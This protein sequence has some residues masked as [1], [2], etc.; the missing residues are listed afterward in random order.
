M[1]LLGKSAARLLTFSLTLLLCA[2]G[3]GGGG[4][5]KTT[6][7]PPPPPPVKIS[8]TGAPLASVNEMAIYKFQVMVKNASST[9]LSFSIANLPTW[10]TFDK[11]TGELAG[12]PSFE[13]AGLYENIV[14]SVKDGA[15]SASLSAFNVQVINV[16]RLPIVT[17][18]ESVEALEGK[19][20]AITVETTDLD[21]DSLSLSLEGQPDW[22]SFDE[23]SS[24]IIG[25]ASL[26]DAGNYQFQ[27]IADDGHS[28]QASKQV[29]VL[30]K[31]A[32]EVRGKVIDGYIQGAKVY[33]DE[34]SNDALDDDEF[35]AITDEKGDYVLILPL[36]KISVL[37]KSSVRAYIGEGAIDVSRPELDFSATPITLSLPPID[38]EQITD[39]VY[40]GAVI[41]PFSQQLY[42]MV[43][44][45]L[46]MLDSGD[47]SVSELQYFIDRAKTI[48][49]R[50][51]IDEGNITL[52]S[53][54]TESDVY[55]II[56]G[57]FIAHS[58]SLS[59]IAQQ[60]Q[61]FVDRYIS[62][63]GAADFDGDG[64]PNDTDTD[65]DGDNVSDSED[66]FPFDPT[67]W[68]DSDGDGVGDNAD[69]YPNNANCSVESDGNGDTCY[70]DLLASNT[71]TLSAISSS[72]VAYFYQQDGLLIAYDLITQ[73]VLN[74]QQVENV[75]SMIFHEGH[76]RLYLGLSTEELKYAADDYSLVDFLPQAQCVNALVDA[77]DFLIVLDC[78]GYAGTYSTFNRD[79]RLLDNSENH[80]DSSRTNTWDNVN[81]RLFHFNDGIS[82]NDLY[83]RTVNDAGEFVDVVESPHHGDYSIAGPIVVS[84]DG[85][86]VLL[87]TGDIYD[88]S[89]LKW[90]K[91]LGERFQQ[92]FW[93]K[94]NDLVVLLQRDEKIH[95]K[96][97][98]GNLNLVEIDE[99]TG[100]LKVVKSFTDR[101]IIITEFDE[102]LQVHD[103]LPSN[104]SDNDGVIN[105]EDAFP[106]DNTAS[107]DSDFDGYPN[108]WNDGQSGAGSQLQI[109][110]FPQDSACWLTSHGSAGS[111]NFL[112]TQPNFT[113]DKT[114]YDA[115]GNIYFLSVEN[116]RVYRWSA[117]TREFTNPL[118]LSVGIFRDYGRSRVMAY[119][120]NHNRLYLG[121][122]SGIISYFE[123]GKQNES[124]LTA[125]GSAVNGIAA[126][127]NY[128]LA[129]NDD[130]AW[131]THYILDD[132]GEITDSKDWN[133]HSS[134]YAW[135]SQNSRVYFLRDG[136]SPND[137]HY[138][139]IDQTLG[140]I[141]ADGESPYHSSQNISHPVRVSDDGRYIILGSGAVFN[142]ADLTLKS[143][144]ELRLADVYSLGDKLYSVE[145]K[146]DLSQVKIWKFE[147]LSLTGL[148]EFSGRALAITRHGDDLNLVSILDDGSLS[149]RAIGIVDSDGDGLPLW[150]ENKYG[151]D[152]NDASD[153]VLDSDNDG[154]SNLQEYTLKTNPIIADTDGDGLL[155]GA[156]V[157]THS[158]SPLE[159]DSDK[160]GLSDGAEV[161]EHGTNPLSAD[162]DNDGLTDSQEILEYN[163]NPLNSDTD[164]DGL[165]D[166]Y[167]VNNRLDINNNDAN[168]DTDNDGLVNID[169]QTHRT[170]PNNPDSDNDKLNDGDEVHTHRT[171]PLN[172]DTDNDKMP[173]GWEVR[174]AFAPLSASD[175]NTDFDADGFSNKLEFFLV[176]DPTDI[177]NVPIIEP[178]SNHQ[179]NAG[180]N[181]FIPV[182]INPANLSTRWTVTLGD[183]NDMSPAIVDNGKVILTG[184]DYS[185]N[186]TLFN[187]NARN[188]SLNWSNTYDNLYSISAPSYFDNKAYIQLKSQ[189]S[190]K[191]TAIDM[192]SGDE[193]FASNLRLFADLDFS[194]TIL[195]DAVYLAGYK[196]NAENG[197]ELWNLNRQYCSSRSEVIDSE[198]YYY[199]F[200]GFKIASNETGEIIAS[201][202]EGFERENC[203]S[204]VYSKTGNVYANINSSIFAF[205]RQTAEVVWKIPRTDNQNF[206]GTPAVALG[207]VYIVKSNSLFVFDEYTGN[208]LWS[209]TPENNDNL[210]TNI[211]VSTNLVFVQ[212]YTNT[213]AIDLETQQQVW[214]YPASGKFTLSKEGALFITQNNGVVTAINLSGD[215]DGDG[216]DDWWEDLYGFDSE[217]EEDA[218]LDT[219]GDGL[220]NLEEF[221]N[222]TDPQNEDSDRDGLSDFAEVITYRSNPLNNDTDNDGMP[223]HWEVIHGFNL[224][225]KFDADADADGDGISNLNEFKENT[226]PTDDSSKPSVIDTLHISFETDVI[227]D[228]WVIDESQSS[229][230]GISRLESSNG[231]H[232]IFSSGEAAITYTNFFNGN[233]LIF[234]FKAQCQYNSSLSIYIDD[235]LIAHSALSTEWRSQE[236]IVPRGRHSIMFKTNDCGV[237]LDNLQFSPLLSLFNMNIETVTVIGQDLRFFNFNKQFTHSIKI[238][239]RANNDARDLT[240]LEDGRIAIFNGV[241]EPSLS[242]YNPLHGTWRHR[243]YDDWGIVNNSTYGGIA[244]FG[245]NVFVTDM[246]IAGDN[247][248]G[249]IRFDIASNEAEFF[250]GE[251]YIDLTV[252]L[253]GLIYALTGRQV[254]KYDPVTMA[255]LTSTTIT[256]ARA[257]AV[258]ADSNLFTASWRGVVKRYDANGVE[259]EQVELS[260]F[261]DNA[262][263]SFYDINISKNNE[264]LLTN[265]GFEVFVLE[266]DFSQFIR[267]DDNIRGAFIALVPFVDGDSDGM[268]KW[269]EER[270][271]FSDADGTDAASDLD[272]EGLTNLAEYLNKTDPS[273]QDT[274]NDLLDDFV[275]VNDHE[276]NPLV[277]DTDKDNLSDG[278]EVLTHLTDPLLIDTDGDTFHDGDEVLVYETDPNDRESKPESV[279]DLNI[280]FS[281]AEL[282]DSWSEAEDSDAAW[283][284]ENEMIRSG[285]ISDNQQS[286]IEYK[287]VFSA[288]ALSFDSLLDSEGCCDYLEIHVDGV[289]E[290]QISTQE[291]QSNQLILSAGAHSITFIYRKD[292]SVSN[293]QDAV[294]IDNL[295]F[296]TN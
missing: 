13:D 14:I 145:N 221:Q 97:Y 77:A 270:F 114:V 282:S 265:I 278:D 127:G 172:R 161:N 209:W 273:L 38:V 258:D 113:P 4:S 269:W 102:Q 150:W 136:T 9:S 40:Q 219:D 18:Q 39:D 234:D 100:T 128:V 66:A 6:E 203:A 92:A 86:S 267:Q 93:L 167:E 78:N 176:S 182:T 56:F 156:E 246:S 131:N 67:E 290:L 170:D 110:A 133:R 95:L 62:Q 222:S 141:T 33:L 242:I 186:H 272:G 29:T 34:N 275:E 292:G 130:G 268:P 212:D 256:E 243:E 50:K 73:K 289:K 155:D 166:L 89:T 80:Y 129:E 123:L 144:L 276:T 107:L 70:V 132:E 279:T 124:R 227:P 137:L 216:I 75:T 106:L 30:I 257:I 22:I 188:G 87:G 225:N 231:D 54:Q 202:D 210:R 226:N 253:D 271:G 198:Y 82:P 164:G 35:S 115:D 37:S 238:P 122:N 274:D 108:S 55:R 207:Q 277:T 96:R 15:D 178:W 184:K 177:N 261:Y 220:N 76:Q 1:L 47:I 204:L 109:D 193:V 179:A 60:A 185:N 99:F 105:I 255:L 28:E 191:L 187:L 147:D 90:K 266:S 211:L 85:N 248:A 42:V 81:N 190:T 286:K 189:A 91:S 236:I 296:T 291:W 25:K 143:N 247:T 283:I 230:W 228:G 135:N 288:G 168:V 49:T 262:S 45:K 181:G 134:T 213:Y 111:C 229:S 205:N 52:S 120:M 48:I 224:L 158:T 98:D 71:S 169:E 194:P 57:D 152:D 197:E 68:R 59:T 74:T 250:S 24:S 118:I 245:D 61:T 17:L 154:L 121:Y 72:S 232:S 240:I 263:G 83:Y 104:D 112:S 206:N 149:V 287:N 233:K 162:S 94:N 119:S 31:E 43:A 218:L 281:A 84:N 153:A 254:D 8:L 295:T 20:L 32:V 23:E 159:A 151:F 199:F 139:T 44:D 88:V 138:E 200:D 125:L 239:K 148:L 294:F 46:A 26:S 215:S 7:P 171:L 175:G 21:A 142:A 146:D 284:L 214:S 79:G 10:A 183:I 241:F 201:N 5:S 103:Y 140:H 27:F 196:F 116:K 223:D 260:D 117:A 58:T 244:H 16:N 11:T 249:I 36:D 101:A 19:Q 252:G 293:G 53:S 192:V 51:I 69:A 251:E 264:L 174:F 2:C 3:G 65:D 157:N 64:I 259:L 160:D 165:L 173:D 237:Y 280:D 208:E 235:V 163:S 285:V 12:T 126:T 195:G 63:Q 41:S 217:D 180:H